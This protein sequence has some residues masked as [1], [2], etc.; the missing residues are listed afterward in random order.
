MRKKEIIKRYAICVVGLL[1]T[2]LGVAVATKAG[3]GTSPISAI[4]YTVSLILPQLTIGNWT[5]VYNLLLVVGHMVI[6][7]NEFRRPIFIVKMLLVQLFVVFIF[8][9]GI[10][11][12]VF[13]MS[14]VSPE[15]YAVKIL[16]LLASCVFI[17]FGVYLQLISNV[18]LLPGDLFNSAIAKVLGKEYGNVRVASDITMSLIAAVL[19][20]IFLGKLIGVRE[21]TVIA[22][23]IVGNIINFFNAHFE[24]LNYFLLPENKIMR[25]QEEKNSAKSAEQAEQ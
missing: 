2:A 16:M 20:L 21:G 12:W 7:H 24:R 25:R 6:L 9:Y 23:L 8:G 3:L 15:I 19:C 17:A 10:D 1:C 5:I 4:P 13:C 18:A 11:F 22:A 14:A